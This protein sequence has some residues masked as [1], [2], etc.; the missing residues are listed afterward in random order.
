VT[1]EAIHRFF[2]NDEF[3]DRVVLRPLAHIRFN[4]DLIWEQSEDGYRPED[5]SFAALVNALIWELGKLTPPSRY[6]DNEDRLAEYVRDGGLGWPIKKVH[7]RWVGA[8]YEAILQQGAWKDVDQSDLAQAAAGRVWA[9]IRFDQH[10]FEDMEKS[11]RDM[12]GAVLSI[13]LYHR[14]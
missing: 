12:L 14:Q 4:W 6:H 10:H 1:P 9:A 13:I 2:A 8:D 11:H 7:G 5:D 3:L